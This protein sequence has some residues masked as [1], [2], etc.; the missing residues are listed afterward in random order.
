MEPRRARSVSSPNQPKSASDGQPRP[1]P[2]ISRPSLRRSRDAVS[3]ASLA[4]RRRGSAATIGP[5]RIRDGR[6]GDRREGDPRVRDLQRPGRIDEQVVPDEEP[7]PARVLG[8]AGKLDEGAGVTAGPEVRDLDRELHRDESVL[9][10]GDDDHARGDCAPRI[11]VVAPGPGGRGGGAA[12]PRPR[13][14]DARDPGRAAAGQPRLLGRPPGPG[15][16]LV[17]R[18]DHEHGPADP[19]PGS[20]RLG[21]RDGG[22]GRPLDAPRPRPRPAGRRLR[23]PLG[24]PQDDVLRGPRAGRAHRGHPDLGL[25]RRADPG[26][27]PPRDVPHERPARPLAGRV[28]GGGPGPGGPRARSRART[29]S[30]RPSST[31]A[32]SSARPWPASSRPRSARVPRSRIDAVTFAISA[33]ALLLVRRPLRPRRAA[34][35]THLLA[36]IREGIAYVV[37]QPT[38]RA[39]IALWTTISVIYAGLTSGLIFYVT[40]DRGLGSDVVGLVL[41]AF[42]VGLARRLAGGRTDGVPGRRAGDARRQPS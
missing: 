10:A 18:R 8:A 37:R 17:R 11:S 28:H 25:A 39:V 35:P 16:Q 12:P 19:R 30:S 2:R 41:S 13:G 6:L 15:D 40:I 9:F 4:G 42:A 23:R 31:S 34:E 27:H 32:G 29:P 26:P 22:R 5:R 1:T 24:P 14:R 33:G 7:V 20:H 3:R 38:L 36:D 21:P